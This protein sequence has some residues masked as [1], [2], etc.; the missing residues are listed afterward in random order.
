MSIEIIRI[1]DL[2]VHKHHLN[3]RY[4]AD[5]FRFST[6]VFY[7]DVSFPLLRQ[8]YSEKLIDKIVAYIA[9]FEG[10]KLCSLFPEYYDISRVSP[11]LE[12]EALELFVTIYQGVFGQHWYENQVTD[13]W[14]PKIIYSQELGQTN[15]GVILGENPA[16]LIGCGGGKDS[17]VGM[18]IL[19]E[20]DLFFAT[21]QYSHS[22]YGKSNLQHSLI[23]E[24]VGEV[25]PI[26]SH[27][28]SIFD[29]FVDFPFFSLYFPENSGMIAPETPVSVFEALPVML[30]EGYQ[31]LSLAHEKSA[32]TGNLILGKNWQGSQSSMG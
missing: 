20:S 1:D 22:V 23:T 28:I 30:N 32:N 8:R 17:V 18:K 19:S 5:E 29:N 24:V 16:I 7:H 3:I 13:Y 10:M 4:S 15:R 6:Q 27:K 12:P 9:L 11:Q 31:F 25:N 14:Q 2:T 21:M 26:K